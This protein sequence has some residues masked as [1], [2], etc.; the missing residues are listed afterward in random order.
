M[1]P[2]FFC[3]KDFL[4]FKSNRGLKNTVYY[5]YIDRF[6]WIQMILP[7]QTLTKEQMIK[8]IEYKISTVFFKN[9]IKNFTFSPIHWDFS[10][11]FIKSNTIKKIS[12]TQDTKTDAVCLSLMYVWL[13]YF[14]VNMIGEPTVF[15]FHV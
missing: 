9:K 3:L 6:F 7:I 5:V 14:N 1:I 12:K 4:K 10:F 15:H 8:I 2:F 11:A 13:K